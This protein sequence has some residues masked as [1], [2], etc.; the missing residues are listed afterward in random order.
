VLTGLSARSFGRFA[1][2]VTRIA[3]GHVTRSL[4]NALRPCGYR[5]FSMYPWYGAFLGARYFQKTLGI[6][7]FLD[8]K[9]IG[10]KNVEPDSFYY[11]YAADLIGRE[12]KQ[13]PMFVLTYLMAN[14]FPWDFRFRPDLAKDWH[15]LG[16]AVV[17]THMI[18]EYLR[19]QHMSGVDYRAFTDRLRKDFPDERFLIVRFGDH[20]PLF[21]KK[22]IGAGLTDTEIGRQIFA[23]DPR[24]YTTYYAVDALNF[25]PHD[26]SEAVDGLD[27]AYLPLIVMNAAGVPLDPAFTEQQ[28]ILKN[29]SGL[30]FLC[31][32]GGPVRRFNR[33]L[34]NAGLIK[35]L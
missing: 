27:A 26:L 1:E 35:G 9:D 16:N 11:N 5:S 31:N 7:H 34:I 14:H 24:Y 17:D 4:P 23:D 20:Q 6:D 13:G 22:A 3:G 15:D 25:K 32:G 21:A 33:M 30:F 2:F 29:C 8:A 10:T 18:D 12:G 28:R 19:R